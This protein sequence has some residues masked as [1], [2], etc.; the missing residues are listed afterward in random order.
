M[1]PVTGQPESYPW[2][3]F[4]GGRVLLPKDSAKAWLSGMLHLDIRPESHVRRRYVLTMD[5][6]KLRITACGRPNA[7]AG[8]ILSLPSRLTF[9]VHHG[10]CS[11]RKAH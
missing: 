9:L 11:L 2:P 1:H 8:F 3:E 10:A 5:A 7:G 6:G 4:L